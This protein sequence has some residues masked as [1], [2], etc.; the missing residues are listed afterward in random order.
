MRPEDYTDFLR[1]Q[2]Q[3][4]V[5]NVTS[6]PTALC[7][8]QCEFCGRSNYLSDDLSCKGCGAPIPIAAARMPMMLYNPDVLPREVSLS[9]QDGDTTY[10][11]SEGTPA[12][13]VLGRN[14]PISVPEHSRISDSVMSMYVEPRWT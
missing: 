14:I 11:R 12:M 1:Q 6:S 10:L 8:S 3:S 5:D 7:I 13:G 2:V 9:Y 4:L